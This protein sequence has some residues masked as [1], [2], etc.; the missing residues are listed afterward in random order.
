MCP[1]LAD[2]VMVMVLLCAYHVTVMYSSCDCHVIFCMS[3]DMLYMY[4]HNVRVHV[5]VYTVH[6]YCTCVD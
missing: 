1:V 3:W 6:M 5:H 4:M 2:D